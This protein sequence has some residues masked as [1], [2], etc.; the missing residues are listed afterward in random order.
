MGSLS[1]REKPKTI[2]NAINICNQLGYDFKLLII[3][4]QGF[5]FGQKIS[6]NPYENKI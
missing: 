6:Y 3:G 2:F 4:K 1:P 5:N